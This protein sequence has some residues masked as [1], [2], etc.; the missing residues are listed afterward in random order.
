[1]ESG[2]VGEK[3]YYKYSRTGRSGM[4]KY[5]IVKLEILY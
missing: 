1:M 2:V 3:K 5:K 4:K